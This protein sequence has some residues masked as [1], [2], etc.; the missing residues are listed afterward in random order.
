MPVATSEPVYWNGLKIEYVGQTSF[1]LALDSKDRNAMVR[2]TNEG[3]VAVNNLYYQ[4]AIEGLGDYP[5]PTGDGG[6]A[7]FP[8][9]GNIDLA[10]G[11]SYVAQNWLAGIYETRYGNTPPEL[12]QT[13]VY[14]FDFLF[15]TDNRYFQDADPLADGSKAVKL[16]QDLEFTRT[17]YDGGLTGP[18]AIA[19]T[20]GNLGLATGDV[21]VEIATPYSQW[22]LLELLQ[23]GDNAFSASVPDRDDWIIRVSGGGVQTETILAS[24]VNQNP[25]ALTVDLQAQTL[26][27][28]GYQVLAADDAPTGFWKGAVSESEQT[29][30]LIPGQENWAGQGDDALSVQ[31]REASEI[32]K[33]T[34]DGD[35]LWTYE[36]GWEAWGGDMTA[37]GSAV[38]YMINPTVTS[39]ANPTF[40][41]GLIDGTTGELRWSIRDNGKLYLGGLEVAISDD[42]QY[43]AAGGTT[44]SLG[45]LSGV[46]GSEIWSKPH[47][48]YGQIRKMEFIDDHL[49]VGTGDGFLY[50]LNVANGDQVWKAYVGGWPFVNGLD[51]SADGQFITVGTKSKDTVVLRADTGEVMWAHQTGTLDAVFSPN[52]QYVANFAGDIFDATTG[53]LIGQTYV[54]GTAMFSLDSQTLIQ[55][56]RGS[57]S[58]SDLGGVLQARYLDA[59][60]TEHG[61]G[62]QAQWSYLTADGSR[63]IVA[64]RDMNTPGERGVTI[65]EQSESAQNSLDGNGGGGTNPPTDPP[66]QLS[67]AL[68]EV[69]AVGLSPDGHYLILKSDGVSQSLSIAAMLQ[70]SDQQTSAQ[71]LADSI[72]HTPVYASVVN[73][74]TQYVLPD[75]FVGPESLNLK[76]Q[77]IDT[78]PNAV[79]VGSADNEFIKLA[80]AT[81]SGKA[82]DGRAGDDVIDGGVGSTFISG[83]AGSNTF[84]LDGRASGTSWSTITDFKLGTDKATVWGWKAGVSYVDS[85]EVQGGASGFEG[86]T[87]HFK[88]LLPDGAG[89]DAV[90]PSLNSITFSDMT[91]A[92]FGANSLTELNQQ[93]AAQTNA[94]FITGH[95]SDSLGEHGYLYIS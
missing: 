26:D 21:R 10:P 56:D 82:V 77:L 49:Y 2:I 94:H 33:Y 85:I 58:I 88:N 62:E 71:S 95:T 91:L 36:P 80:H 31:Y 64:S 25:D 72:T 50:K 24:E 23:D 38:V 61:A 75:A 8:N 78:T 20:V 76:Y 1:D 63:L 44:G 86:I 37:D 11:E 17:D 46:D 54:A 65:W 18:L 84:F 66:I 48:T 13:K 79:I 68:A 45:L 87:L 92:D 47:D 7:V 74:Q 6:F 55:A 12:G 5:K 3:S 67:M 51:L 90:N 39:Y 9:G 69:D 59:S 30:V 70:F 93:I 57:I 53:D 83:G 16:E 28:V 32:R 43:V 22:Y 27:F 29:F 89:A 4:V 52:G 42:G 34:F 15:A 73:G 60:D 14:S 40:E 19:G 41:V 35:L 81:S